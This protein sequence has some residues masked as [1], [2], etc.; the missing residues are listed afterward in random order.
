M[1]IT[2]S[3]NVSFSWFRH[4]AS[5]DRAQ[6]NML[7]HALNT[8][9]LEWDWLHEMELSESISPKT[10]WIPNHLTVW[11]EN[12]LVAAAPLYI[13]THSEGEFVYDSVWA[14][15]AHRL[16]VRYFPKMVGMS[17]VTPVIGYRFLMAP[18]MDEKE[19]TRLMLEQ[20]DHVCLR[21][22][23]SGCSFLF[24]E[25]AWKNVMENLGYHGWVHQSFIW[26]NQGFKSFQDYLAQFRSN[27]RRNIRREQKVV[28][29]QELLLR[30]FFKDEIPEQFLS[31]MYDFYVRTNAKFG[32]WG[33]KYL[34][35]KFFEGLYRNYRHR[36]L[37]VAAF[38]KSESNIPS[39]M[40]LLV[41]KEDQLYGR[42]WGCNQAFDS[43]HFNTCYYEPIRW[44]IEKGIQ[45]YHP[46]AGGLHKVRRGFR[47]I[48]GYSLLRFYDLK[49]QNIMIHHISEINQ[50]EQGEIDQINTMLPFSK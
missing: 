39:A 21:N 42:Y 48:A 44:A 22:K 37:F 2:K 32:P 33:C 19:I 14:N 20:I 9:F 49:L 31:L 24:V 34:T 47:A 26:E 43:L 5:I 27:Q 35:R 11:S 18:D 16:G 36:L 13:K 3:L 25:P 23:L 41:N 1:N 12:R 50:L 28:E 10:G 38:K 4:M 17:P 40:A 6:W 15:V 45:T 30:T 8:P 7:A 46:G 29:K